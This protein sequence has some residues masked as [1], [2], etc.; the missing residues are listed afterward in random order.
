M[1]TDVLELT[2]LQRTDRLV[3]TGW[4]TAYLRCHNRAWVEAHGLGWTPAETEAQMIVSDVV[5]EHWH[6]LVRVAGAAGNRVR[7]ARQGDRPLGVAWVGA[8]R[9]AYLKI[10]TGVIQW[11]Y[12]CPRAR[13]EGV[14]TRLLEDGLDWMRQL[15]LRSAEVSVLANNE[16]AK[17]LY[18]RFGLATADVRM[19]GAL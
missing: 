10:P 13:G 18:S 16:P 3:M 14:A 19:M 5:D 9:H 4:L 12:T 7:V 2:P 1:S 6:Q 11:I 15:E 8:R 17:R